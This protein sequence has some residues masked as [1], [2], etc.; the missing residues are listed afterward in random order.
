[1]ALPIGLP[2]P[3]IKPTSFAPRVNALSAILSPNLTTLAPVVLTKLMTF[4]AINIIIE[5]GIS[6]EFAFSSAYLF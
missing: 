4:L 3:G 6:L 5:V 1:M 2:M